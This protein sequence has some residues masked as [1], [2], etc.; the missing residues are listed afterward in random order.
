MGRK[1]R[2]I[3]ILLCFERTWKRGCHLEH[4][5]HGKELGSIR[6]RH[7]IKN[8]P[9]LASTQFRIH[10]V[11]KNFYSESRFRKLRIRMPDSPDTFGQNPH[12]KRKSC[13]FKN[14]QIRVDGALVFFPILRRFF[15]WNCQI[16][17]P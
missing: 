2:E 13:R 11:F 3:Y 5:I 14:I 15:Q 6:L 7:R 1:K 16:F 4:S 12:P 17:W 8:F 10:S 9:D